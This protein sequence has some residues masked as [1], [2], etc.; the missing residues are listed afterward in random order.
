MPTPNALTILPGD[1]TNPRGPVSRIVSIPPEIANL[2]W[3]LDYLNAVRGQF[4]GDELAGVKPRSATRPW[5]WSAR[6]RGQRL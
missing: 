5:N 2:A 3:A 6:R 1:D 4:A